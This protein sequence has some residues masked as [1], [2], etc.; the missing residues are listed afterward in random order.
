MPATAGEHQ[1]QLDSPAGPTDAVWLRPDDAVAQMVLAHGAGA[2]CRHATMQGI[3]E[4][5]AEA[6]IATLR[7][8]FPFMQSSEGGK[9]R[10]VDSKEVCIS[11]ITSA[12]AYLEAHSDLP[13]FLGGHSFGGRM[14]SHAVADTALECAGLIYCSFPLHPPKKPGSARAAHL[15]QIRQPQLF[16]SGTRDDLADRE[17]LTG[18]VAGL[19]DS[20]AVH[21]LETANHSYVILKRVRTSGPPVFTEMARVARGFVD[22]VI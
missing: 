13:L 14:C 3:A 7:F 8:N 11:C 15:P 4:A 6:G 21:W 16:L 2:G 18:V 12:A 5:F 1:L 20:A 22:E 9:R 17:L 10:R 19:G